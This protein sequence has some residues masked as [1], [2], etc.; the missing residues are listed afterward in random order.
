MPKGKSK[1][2]GVVMVIAIGGKPPKKPEKT[3]DVKKQIDPDEYYDLVE[4]GE[5]TP[6]MA[7][8]MYRDAAHGPSTNM[9][10]LCDMKLLPSGECAGCRAKARTRGPIA[11][12]A[13]DRREG[14]TQAAPQTTAST[15]TPQQE[16]A[17]RERMK[18]NLRTGAPMDLS[19]RLLKNKQ[20]CVRCSRLIDDKGSNA[21]LL[22]SMRGLCLDCYG[23]ERGF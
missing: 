10:T 6:E 3:S 23:D 12:G 14:K 1:K 2:T 4:S 16:D 19:W 5:I 15:P 9:C 7:S 8:Q 18:G 20:R 11:Q 17:E 22:A 21:E 13:I